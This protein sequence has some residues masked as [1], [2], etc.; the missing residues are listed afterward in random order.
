V[1]PR[2]AVV[3][4][5]VRERPG[6]RPRPGQRSKQQDLTAA[7][8]AGAGVRVLHSA[9]PADTARLLAGLVQ[10]EVA[11]ARGLPPG[12][13]PTVWQEEMVS[14][15]LLLPGLGLGAALVLAH[16]FPSLRRLVAAPAALLEERGLAPGLAENLAGFLRHRFRPSLADMAPL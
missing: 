12:L 7:Q 16:R 11:R 3:V 5:W 9:G 8:L 15:L 6:E 13:R 14:W 10:G 2:L 4:E 1:Y